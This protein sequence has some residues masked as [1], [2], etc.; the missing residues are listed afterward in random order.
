[1]TKRMRLRCFLLVLIF[2]QSMIL[3]TL[4]NYAYAKYVKSETMGGNVTVTVDIG[5]ILLREHRAERQPDGSYELIGVDSSLLCD[6]TDHSHPTTNSYT[7]LPG[8]DVP[9]DPHVVITKPNLLPVY[10]YVE[11][12]DGLGTDSGIHYSMSSW[13]KMDGV[14]GLHGGTVYYYPTP[15]TGSQT[16]YLLDNN[17]VYVSQ[18][19]D[20]T[21]YELPL[22]FYA[23]MYQTD[24]GSDALTVYQ[25][26][27]TP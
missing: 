22:T 7:L 6:G 5:T 2:L 17:T 8:L 14:T 10:I 3:S 24:A 13:T 4:C 20:K 12:V 9:K 25:N 23:Y 19:L 27:T 18:K 26:Y 11:V 21:A 16:L 1:M 15:V